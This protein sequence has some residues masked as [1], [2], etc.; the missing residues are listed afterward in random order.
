MQAATSQRNNR[1]LE[2]DVIYYNNSLRWFTM[3]PHTIHGPTYTF[4]GLE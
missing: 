4:T 1:P 3:D 2:A